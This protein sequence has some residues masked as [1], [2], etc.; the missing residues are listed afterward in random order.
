MDLK[1]GSL[2]SVAGKSALVTGGSRG[3][4]EMIARGLVENGVRVYISS[5]KADACET[6]ANELSAFGTCVAIPADISRPEEVDRLAAA[7][8]EREPKLDILVNNAGT[9]W[10]EPFD[11]FS[12]KGWD[13]VMDLNVKALFFLTQRLADVLHNAGTAD[14]PARVINIGSIDG[15]VA[16][17]FENYSYSASKA[18]VHQLTRHLARHLAP[19][20]ISVNA[21]APGYFPSKMTEFMMTEDPDFAQHI[22]LRRGGTPED[23]AGTVLYMASRAGTYL[24]GSVITV[25]GGLTAA[26]R[27][28]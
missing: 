7:V 20:H 1:I 25:D 17:V 3:I 5:R 6:L 23:M 8:A 10:G 21:I 11:D 18:A 26:S 9:A 16:P 14:D 28:K 4:G 13:R 2:F 12:E 22:P 24:C 15:L 27:A 19:R